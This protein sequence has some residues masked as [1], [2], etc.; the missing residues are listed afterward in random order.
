MTPS[1]RSRRCTS[2]LGGSRARHSR[3][4]AALSSGAG[5]NAAD[6]DGADRDAADQAAADAV[7]R[8]VVAVADGGRP[9]AEIAGASAGC[10]AA[11]PVGNTDRN[12]ASDG[13]PVMTVTIAPQE[14]ARAHAPGL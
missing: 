13:T 5:V 2:P 4:L 8:A 10:G 6:P 7:G 11:R 3:S 12:V 14:T 1:H 9:T